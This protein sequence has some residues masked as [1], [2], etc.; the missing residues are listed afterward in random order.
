MMPAKAKHRGFTLLELMAVVTLLTVALG[1]VL[2]STAGLTDRA[3][4]RAAAAQIG[5]IYRLALLHAR[6]S[7]MPRLLQFGRRGCTVSKPEFREEQW[8]WSSGASMV[9]A[10]KVSI[11]RVWPLGGAGR[12]PAGGPWS[13]VVAPNTVTPGYRFELQL[14][15]ELIGLVTIDGYTGRDSFSPFVQEWK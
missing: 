8:Q 2:L 10:E 7:G 13:I 4:L 14:E 1:V 3:R 11:R 9:L 12:L 6:E 5:T 15:N